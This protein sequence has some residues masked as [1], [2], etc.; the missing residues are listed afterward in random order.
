MHLKSYDNWYP[1]N[2][3]T[4]VLH[5]LISCVKLRPRHAEW[6][7]KILP[8]AVILTDFKCSK[9]HINWY[10]MMQYLNLVNVLQVSFHDNN[11]FCFRFIV[12]LGGGWCKFLWSLIHTTSANALQTCSLLKIYNL[13]KHTAWSQALPSH[14]PIYVGDFVILYNRSSF[15]CIFQFMLKVLNYMKASWSH[16]KLKARYW[17]L[18]FVCTLQLRVTIMTRTKL[19]LEWIDDTVTGNFMNWKQLVQS[20]NGL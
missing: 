10:Q 1:P 4:D 17:W 12:A 5:Y 14:L 8:N 2:S 20:W 6:S 19:L 15:V 3:K 7:L 13:I 11:F 18:S 16:R 9:A